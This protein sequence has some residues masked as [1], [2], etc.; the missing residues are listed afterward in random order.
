MLSFDDEHQAKLLR[1]HE[2]RKGRLWE[3]PGSQEEIVDEVVAQ[4]MLSV[5]NDDDGFL[6]V[7]YYV[8]QLRPYP[9]WWDSPAVENA[10]VMAVKRN[11]DFVKMYYGEDDANATA[12]ETFFGER[13][14]L[15]YMYVDSEKTSAAIERFNN[16]CESIISAAHKVG[17]ETRKR[18]REAYEMEANSEDSNGNLDRAIEALLP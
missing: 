7:D 8:K 3:A 12:S 9:Q 10:V 13:G 5:K 16:L 14:L 17:A 4:L 1:A 15:H 6:H 2:I 11:G 18:N